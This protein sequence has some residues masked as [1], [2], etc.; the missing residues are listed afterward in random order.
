M[1]EGMGEL[2]LLAAPVAAA[3]LGLL[4][5]PHCFAMCGGIVA[6]ID[7]APALAGGAAPPPLVRHLL[8]SVGRIASYSLAGLLVGAF[9]FALSGWLGP[10]GVTALRSAFGCVMIALG[11]HLTGIWLATA[12]I[13][14]AALAFWRRRVPRSLITGSRPLELLGFGLIWGWLPCGLVYGALAGAATAGS[15]LQGALWM[16]SFGVGTLP[17]LLATGVLASRLRAATRRAGLRRAAG[18]MLVLFGLWTIA[19]AQLGQHGQHG[20]TPGHSCAVGI[21]ASSSAAMLRMRWA[22]AGSDS[23]RSSDATTRASRGAVASV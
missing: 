5:S 18:A 16:A 3:T 11:I 6:A 19:G 1:T 4:G 20:S 21:R 10:S 8:Y 23:L 22:R 9:G 14:Q 15:G 7:Q 13:E 17:A 2:S 12:R